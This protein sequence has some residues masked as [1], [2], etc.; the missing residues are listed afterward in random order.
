VNEKMTYID[1]CLHDL[2]QAEVPYIQQLQTS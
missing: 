1:R 2:Y